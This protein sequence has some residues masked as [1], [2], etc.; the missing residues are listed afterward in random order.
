MFFLYSY[1]QGLEN[2]YFI[3]NSVFSLLSQKIFEA[4]IMPTGYTYFF[5]K[6]ND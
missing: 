6:N 2:M 4:F 5:A 3:A 1:K